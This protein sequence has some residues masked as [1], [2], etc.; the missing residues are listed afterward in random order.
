MKLYL[1]KQED[2]NWYDT[3]DSVVVAAPSPEEAIMI[4]PSSFARV[5]SGKFVK[6]DGQWI[7]EARD[8]AFGPSSVQLEYIGEAKEGTEAG[9]ILASFNAG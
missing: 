1:L 7:S 3:F 9:V 2:N 6:G 4:H 5:Q 8:W